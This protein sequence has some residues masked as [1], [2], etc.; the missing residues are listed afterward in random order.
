MTEWEQCEKPT[1]ERLTSLGWQYKRGI[2]ILEDEREPLLISRLKR[3]IMR[4][5][6]IG[7]KE[8]EEVITI[9]KTI[10]FGVEGSRK[11]QKK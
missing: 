4:T 9:L 2:E 3:A 11:L 5:N 7:E 10:P 1:I 6:G 8:A